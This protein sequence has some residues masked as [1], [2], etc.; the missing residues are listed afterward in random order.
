MSPEKE[1]VTFNQC[2]EELAQSV[3]SVADQLDKVRDHF[4]L[5]MEM[6]PALSFERRNFLHLIAET[7]PEIKAK[8]KVGDNVMYSTD[9]SGFEFVVK[10]IKITEDGVFYSEISGPETSDWLPQDSIHRVVEG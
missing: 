7:T 5:Y 6:N 3:L 9:S 4:K 1:A 10:E 8:Y 2:F